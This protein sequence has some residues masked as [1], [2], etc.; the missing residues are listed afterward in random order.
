MTVLL[1]NCDSAIKTE[2]VAFVVE[3]T[4][5]GVGRP[6]RR[7]LIATPKAMI[8]KEYKVN[9]SSPSDQQRLPDQEVCRTRYLG[10]LFGFSDCLAGAPEKCAYSLK[11]HDGFLCRHPERRKFELSEQRTS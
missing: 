5:H 11:F 8:Y 2:S 7:F 1:S 6:L 3:S 9:S 10:A 4:I